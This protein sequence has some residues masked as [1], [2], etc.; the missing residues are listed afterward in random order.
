VKRVL[1]II[2]SVALGIWLAIALLIFLAQCH[3]VFPR[4]LLP[5]VARMKQ[6][7]PEV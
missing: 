5:P 1:A 3:L 4:H 7:A 6:L 2:M